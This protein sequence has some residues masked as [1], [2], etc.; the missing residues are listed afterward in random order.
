MPFLFLLLIL[1]GCGFNGNQK[2]TAQGE[3][4]HTIQINLPYIKEIQEICDVVHSE[5]EVA[6]AECTLEN[7][8][9]FSVDLSGALELAC[10]DADPEDLPPEIQNIC[11]SLPEDLEEG[12]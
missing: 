10:G 12:L 11:G 5:D 8:K 6:A 2:V 1:V 3:S 9:V 4:I 7:I